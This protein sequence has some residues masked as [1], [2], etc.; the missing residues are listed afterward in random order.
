MSTDNT[1]ESVE[2]TE[3]DQAVIDEIN[4]RSPEADP[5]TSEPEVVEEETTVDSTEETVQDETVSDDNS[6]DEGSEID[7]DLLSLAEHYGFN[8]DDFANEQVLAQVIDGYEA[9]NAQLAQWQQWY[10]G[11]NQRQ[12]EQQQGD[13]TVPPQQ[14]SHARPDFTVG[15]GDDYDEGLKEAINA[16][17]SQMANHYD[18]QL[19]IVASHIINQHGAVDGYYQQQQQDYALSEIDAFDNAV[20][21]LGNSG[22]FGEGSF[23]DLEPNSNV[24]KARED[25]YSQVN[26]LRSGY[27]NSGQEPPEFGELVKQAY[28][29][30]FSDEVSKQNQSE[31]ANR[32]RS[33]QSRRLG[34]GTTTNYTS[35]ADYDGDDPV[36]NSKLKDAY[37]SFLKENGEL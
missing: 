10:Q 34:G 1:E 4:D 8:P 16:L 21:S 7:P 6:A 29:S 14:Q 28:N 5:Q 12:G 18:Q 20:N 32:L 23:L 13:G 33:G 2:I 37:E 27:Y 22:L 19:E 26:V 24:S 11:Q 25:L 3:S 17:A 9:G 30:A 15:L 36:N 35:D 31:T